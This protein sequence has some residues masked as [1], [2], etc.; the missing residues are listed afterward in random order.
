MIFVKPVP[1]PKATCTLVEEITDLVLFDGEGN[2]T[3]KNSGSIMLYTY[4]MRSL[5]LIGRILEIRDRKKHR[6]EQKDL[7]HYRSVT[8][9][10]VSLRFGG[11]AALRPLNSGGFLIRDLHGSKSLLAPGSGGPTSGPGAPGPMYVTFSCFKGSNLRTLKFA[12]RKKVSLY[13][14]QIA[15][16]YGACTR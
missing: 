13:V 12:N 10:R 15:A 7:I 5:I 9:T 1:I 2:G 14:W 3:M 8:C 11:L 4:K 16:K 6:K